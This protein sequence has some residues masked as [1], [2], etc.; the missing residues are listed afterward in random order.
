MVKN[1]K[2]IFDITP[3]TM[4][5]FPDHLACIVWF[6]GCNMRCSYCYNPHIVLGEGSIGTDELLDFLRKRTDHLEGVVLSGGECTLYSLLPE[7]CR[8]IKELG[9]KIKLDTNGSKPQ[10][11]SLLLKNALLDFVSLDFKSSKTL[12][13]TVTL[14]NFYDAF[15]ESLQIL[16]T[17]IVPFEV[18][19]TVH[20]DFLNE[21]AI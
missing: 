7:L 21:E 4:L 19:T 14:S 13:K 1:T 12:F 17:N 2:P 15:I 5:D 3:F 9:F 6:A 8:S 20:A 18:R 11:L 16:Q 10:V